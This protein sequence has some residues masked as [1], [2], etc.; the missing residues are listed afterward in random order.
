MQICVVAL[1]KSGL[2]WASSQTT[3]LAELGGL[4]DLRAWPDHVVH[5]SILPTGSLQVCR[6]AAG[7]GCVGCISP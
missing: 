2:L 4:V 1:G 7:S 5:P 3:S 6:S